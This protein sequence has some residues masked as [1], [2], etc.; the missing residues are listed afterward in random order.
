MIDE[1]HAL[2]N[3]PDGSLD[4]AHPLVAAPQGLRHSSLEAIHPLLAALLGLCQRLH[5]LS[6]P[7]HQ[8]RQFEQLVTQHQLAQLAPPLRVR[9]EQ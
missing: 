7:A 6:Q 4:P 3:L 1:A 8:I 5:F 2:R 9:V